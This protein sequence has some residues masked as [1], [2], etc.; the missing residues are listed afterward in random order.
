M[1]NKLLFGLTLCLLALIAWA[2]DI[3]DVSSRTIRY[4]RSSSLRFDS[5]S[6]IKDEDAAWTITASQMGRLSLMQSGTATNSNSFTVT[7]TF[8]TA[9]GSAPVITLAAGTNDLP[10]LITVTTTNVILGAAQTNASIRWI[11]IGSP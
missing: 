9:F 7:N 8:T 3:T 1:K 11:A 2:A 10:H 6:T 4:R 5:T